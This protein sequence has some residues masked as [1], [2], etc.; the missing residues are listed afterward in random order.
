MEDNTERRKVGRPR[1]TLNKP[2]DVVIRKQIGISLE[3][4]FSSDMYHEDMALGK[5]GSARMTLHIG[6]LPYVLTKKESIKTLLNG[7][8][9]KETD[10]LVQRIK[11]ETK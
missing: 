2:A 8:D 3:K 11:A 6:L 9:E 10:A 7:L 1:K 4:Y 5:A